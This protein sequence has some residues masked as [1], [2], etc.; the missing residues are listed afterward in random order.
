M[1]AWD[2][3]TARLGLLPWTKTENGVWQ[4]FL[5]EWLYDLCVWY[6]WLV[7][8]MISFIS[9][10]LPGSYAERDWLIDPALAPGRAPQSGVSLQDLALAVRRRDDAVFKDEDLW[11]L[12]DALPGVKPEEMLK[13]W[14]G[15]VLRSGSWL[16]P[17]HILE[18]PLFPRGLEWGKR[19]LT[20][21]RGDPLVLIWQGRSVFPVPLWG[22]VSLPEISLRGRSSATMVYD[23]QPWK[24]HFRLLDDGKASG[25]RVLL[26]NWTCREKNC[27]W[28]TLEELVS[29]P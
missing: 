9:A 15:K 16:D 12:W 10:R 23:H 17:A 18:A 27:G 6:L 11:R 14:R 1:S 2:T 13:V 8:W 21:Y 20:P 26:G 29:T 5:P 7:N 3:T 19:Y 22:N 25:R 28:F 4:L 24:D